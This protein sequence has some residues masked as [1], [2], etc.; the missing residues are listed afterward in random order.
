MG[1]GPSGWKFCSI[2]GVDVDGEGK[3]RKKVAKEKSIIGRRL[4]ILN[5]RRRNN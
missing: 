3:T 1:R 2:V 4:V 5:S